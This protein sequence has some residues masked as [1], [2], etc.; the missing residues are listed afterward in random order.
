[1][2]VYNDNTFGLLRQALEAHPPLAVILAV[3]AV[4]FLLTVAPSLNKVIKWLE[5]RLANKA[6]A[7]RRNDNARYSTTMAKAA[8]GKDYDMRELA[9]NKRP[10][11]SDI[12]RRP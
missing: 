3:A 8:S 12:Q 5:R 11:R 2:W 7:A 9:R 1:M 6:R 10:F 4:G